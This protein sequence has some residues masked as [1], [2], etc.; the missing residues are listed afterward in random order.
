MNNILFLEY[1]MKK[2]ENLLALG[3]LKVQI[4]LAAEV[5]QVHLSLCP[6]PKSSFQAQVMGIWK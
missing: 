5:Q 1:R 3:F 4:V 2:T 6:C